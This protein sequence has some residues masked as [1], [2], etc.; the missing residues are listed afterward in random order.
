M[1]KKGILTGY[2]DPR[3]LFTRF[4]INTGDM[5]VGNM[6]TP[7]KMD[8]TIMGNAVNLTARLEGVNKK[9]GTGILISGFTKEQAGA[10]FLYHRLDRVRVVGINKP[11][12]LFELT[13]MTDNA[14]EAELLFNNKWEKA[15]TLFEQA[16]SE[17][18]LYAVAKDLFAEML[19]ERPDVGASALYIE[20]CAAFLENPPEPDWDGVFN[21]SEK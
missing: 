15:I 9:Y 17:R 18:R 6:G 13:G 10:G 12:P 7:N 16:L 2:N 1:V 14:D 3:P 19:N 11:V 8:Y 5:V 4:G 20:R 21:L